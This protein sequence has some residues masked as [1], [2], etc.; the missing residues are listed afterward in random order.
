MTPISYAAIGVIAR[1]G[2][3]DIEFLTIDVEYFFWDGGRQNTK[4]RLTKFPGG[5]NEL[6]DQGNPQRTLQ[7]ELFEETGLII[8]PGAKIRDL[9]TRQ[10]NG[11]WKFFYL[12]WRSA[13]R[14]HVRTKVDCDKRS[15]LYVPEW[16]TYAELE[17]KLCPSQRNVLPQLRNLA[18][19]MRP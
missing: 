7:E 9:M 5:M 15:I 3:H 1:R 6:S 19:I 12:V 2:R 16:L 13:C 14:G 10:Y 17:K 18:E 4:Q 11:N 8:K